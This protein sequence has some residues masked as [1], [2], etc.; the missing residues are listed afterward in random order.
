MVKPCV[1]EEAVMAVSHGSHAKRH[2]VA[3]DV[4]PISTALAQNW[5]AIAIRG[6]LGILFGLVAFTYPG[7][8]LL[9]LLYLF[10]AYAVL[11]GGFA[12][13][14][15]YRA[16]RSHRHWGLLVLEGAAGILAGGLAW[17]WPGMSLIAFVVLVGVWALITGALMFRAAF[18]LHIKHGRFGLVFGGVASM[19]FG[20][21]LIA[22]PIVGARV[23]TWWIGVYA[24]V[25]GV[26][27]FF[28]ALRLRTHKNEQAAIT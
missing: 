8:T 24:V 12:I 11:D 14:S 15:A 18:A 20:G 3:N 10:G 16:A 17:F 19:V 25:F 28:L 23:L 21:I 4:H 2:Q 1:N 22:S 6:A 9:S 5:W 27:L 26:S 13:A 7:V